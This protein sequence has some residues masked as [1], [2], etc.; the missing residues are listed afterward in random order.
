MEGRGE[1]VRGCFGG[2]SRNQLIMERLC[3]LLDQFGPRKKLCAD[4]K[5]LTSAGEEYYSRLIGVIYGLASLGVISDGE[6]QH[7]ICELDD[8]KGELNYEDD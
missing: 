4:G 7:I 1:I 3:E 5:T 6:C 2:T 8:I